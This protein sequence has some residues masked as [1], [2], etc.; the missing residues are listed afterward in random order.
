M[1]I[2]IDDK[3][4]AMLKEF[5]AEHDTTMSAVLRAALAAYLANPEAAIPSDIRARGP[6]YVRIYVWENEGLAREFRVMEVT[7]TGELP[8]LVARTVQIP[9]LESLMRADLPRFRQV[10]A[11]THSTSARLRYRQGGA[12]CMCQVDVFR[13]RPED[14][15]LETVVFRR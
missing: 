8:K 3:T 9:E 15:A 12:D 11:R 7:S 4:H 2:N 5:A 1:I 10:L 13:E 14:A 6:W